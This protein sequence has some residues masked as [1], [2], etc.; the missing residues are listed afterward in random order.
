MANSS[1]YSEHTPMPQKSQSLISM[2]TLCLD[3]QREGFVDRLL[4]QQDDSE[5]WAKPSNLWAF[6]G[7]ARRNTFARWLFA[8]V[9]AGMKL[10]TLLLKRVINLNIICIEWIWLCITPLIQHRPLSATQ[11]LLEIIRCQHITLLQA[12]C[13]M[14][15]WFSQILKR[16]LKG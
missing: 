14:K 4:F 13:S 9:I 2:G 1:S 5:E 8:D 11:N 16:G 3:C 15:S 10:Q 6:N 12:P 7:E